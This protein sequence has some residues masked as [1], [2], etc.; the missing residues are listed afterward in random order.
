MRS[1]RDSE[2]DIRMNGLGVYSG[3]RSVY[4]ACL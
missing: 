3:F 2:G 4:T 1:V